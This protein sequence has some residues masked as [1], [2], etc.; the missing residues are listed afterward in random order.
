MDAGVKVP[1]ELEVVAHCNFPWSTPS[2]IPVHRLGFDAREV[3]RAALNCIDAM[4]RRELVPS[5]THIPARF[6]NES[7]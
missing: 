6:E 3:L 7:I 4:G 1:D 5:V 2:S